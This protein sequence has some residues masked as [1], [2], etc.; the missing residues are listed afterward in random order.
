MAVSNFPDVIKAKGRRVWNCPPHFIKIDTGHRHPSNGLFEQQ[1]LG[2][3][4]SADLRNWL[5]T[6]IMDRFYLGPVAE[7]LNNVIIHRDVVAFEN[8]ADATFFLLMR[9]TLS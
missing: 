7:I 9:D 6:H 4:P 1:F 8:P 2:D 5:Y 3:A